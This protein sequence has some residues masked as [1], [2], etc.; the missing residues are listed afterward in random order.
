[1]IRALVA[2]ALAVGLAAPARAQEPPPDWRVEKCARYG[3]AWSEA[4]KRFGRAGLSEDFI[5]RHD[6]FLARGCES[7]RE[8]CPRSK[9]E[10]SLAN[11]MV[12]RAMN[13]GTASTFL[14]F[15]CPR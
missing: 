5:A 6:A 15:A 3:A 2:A 12:L 4:L 13:A 11:V 8:V 7:P 9:E 10:L 14:P 1:M